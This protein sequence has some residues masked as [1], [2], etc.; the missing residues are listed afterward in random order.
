MTPTAIPTA[1]ESAPTLRASK[2][3]DGWKILR[4][5]VPENDLWAIEQLAELLHVSVDTIYRWQRKPLTSKTPKENGR[6]NPID[7]C[8]QL[9][10]ALYGIDPDKGELVFDSFDDLRAE[11]RTRHG[12]TPKFQRGQIQSN[13]RRIGREAD[14]LANAIA[15]GSDNED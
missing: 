4:K 3:M 11:L 13:L 7:Y 6:R 14:Q 2:D 5:A 8:R 15:G 12:R 10:V 1:N 9:I